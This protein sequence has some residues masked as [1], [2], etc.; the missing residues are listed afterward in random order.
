MDGGRDAAIHFHAHLM[1]IL[2]AKDNFEPHW[3]VLVHLYANIS[4]LGEAYVKYGIIQSASAWHDFVQ[5][6]NKEKPLSGF[7]D[8]GG[9]KE[10]AD[11]RIKGEDSTE[12]CVTM[13]PNTN[14]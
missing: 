6:F 7:I 12:I 4:K 5:G 14:V 8:A 10:S 1:K 3:K 2:R 13:I 9:D 11:T